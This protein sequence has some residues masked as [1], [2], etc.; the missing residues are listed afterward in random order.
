MLLNEFQIRVCQNPDCGLRYPLVANSN[1]GERCPVCLG[2]TKA[3][4]EQS[5][6]RDPLPD[7]GPLPTS[8]NC[9]VVLDNIRSALNVGSIFR[10][11]DGFGFQ[12]VYLCGFTPTPVNVEVCKS[13]VGAEQFVEWSTHK[14]AVELIRSLKGEGRQIWVMEKTRT[15]ISI[16]SAV[17]TRE[18]SRSLVLI[19]G[20]EVTGVD[21]GILDIADC[22]VHI[23]MCGQKRSFNVAVAFAVAAQIIWFG[24]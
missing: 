7:N 3:V 9:A 15:S 12:H 2:Q 22:E 8:A 10:S 5:L 4:I 6:I 13:A 20:N 24:V 23:P 19:V 16:N 14:N 1:F 21:P 11:A 17:P 18:K